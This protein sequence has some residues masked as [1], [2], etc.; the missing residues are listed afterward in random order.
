M[1]SSFDVT[2]DDPVEL[3]AVLKPVV[4][5]FV[6]NSE[7][8]QEMQA[9]SIVISYYDSLCYSIE[10]K[11]NKELNLNLLESMLELFVKV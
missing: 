8:I 11:A 3:S 9:N 6:E 4:E 5:N 1:F 10:P 7:L 2:P